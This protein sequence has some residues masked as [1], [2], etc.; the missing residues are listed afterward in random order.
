MSEPKVIALCGSRFAL[1]ALQQLVFFKQLKVVA[2]PENC[3]EMIEN[4][5]LVLTGTGIPVMVLQK[6]TFEKKITEAIKTH[7][8]DTGLILSFSYKIPPS[9]YQL[10]LKG[11]YNVHPGL[12][13]AYRGADPVFQ[14]IRNKE[15]NAGVTIHKVDHDFDTGP[16][17]ISEMIRLNPEDTYGI[18][19]E[20][21]SYTAAKLTGTLLKLLS[22]DITIPSRTQDESK[23]VY[24]RKQVAADVSIN[25]Q[26]MDAATIIAL[27]NACNPW[28]KGAVTKLNNKVIR[29][30]EASCTDWPQ[31]PEKIPGT[32]IAI[33]DRGLVV[34]ALNNQAV[35]V[36]LIY[37][38]EG[39]LLAK[40]LKQFGVMPGV[41]LGLV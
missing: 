8:V 9:V 7:E 16:V 21:L 36:Q 3:E 25:W 32:I 17:V 33:D 5:K 28:N 12:L 14:Q 11:F 38:D 34:A 4:T 30:L 37:I 10:P 20:K 26:V 13:P 41:R 15:K 18:L 27:V 35:F 1:P 6:K 31:M 40:R 29:I 22:F 39:F 24:Y 23:A 2:I 19:N